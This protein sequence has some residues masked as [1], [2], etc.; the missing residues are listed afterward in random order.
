MC[1]GKN[2]EVLIS[3][4]YFIFVEHVFLYITGRNHVFVLSLHLFLPYTFG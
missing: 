2:A 4:P 3:T 1:S